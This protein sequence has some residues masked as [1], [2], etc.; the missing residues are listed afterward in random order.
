[1]DINDKIN[2]IK[3][4]TEEIVTED[5]LFNLLSNNENKILKA[6]VGYEPSGKV[7]L[8]H[9][10]T[11]NKLL[12]LQKIGFKIIVLLADIHAYLNKKGTFEKIKKITEYNKKCFIALGLDENKTNF[13][14]GSTY[15]TNEKYI[16][17]VLKMTK[18]IT[19]N[20]SNRSMD[21]VG[22]QMENPM[23]SQLLYPIMQCIDIAELDIDIAIGGIDQR[24]I[25]ML[26]RE[27]L[28][29]LGYKKPICIHI[30]IMLGLDGKKMSSSNDNFIS[31]DDTSDE[32][33]NKIMKG[34][35]EKGNIINNPILEIFKYHVFPRYTQ[36]VINRS[37]KFGGNIMY[38]KYEDLE[39]DFE[40]LSIHPFDLKSAAIKYINEILD[41]VRNVLKYDSIQ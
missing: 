33:K 16:L 41:P 30:P 35:C 4:N 25:H 24:K 29:S 28:E 15:Q 13:V 26:A 21:E 5:E 9:L 11:V 1:M 17:N 34:F 10:M 27:N 3:R 40:N 22:R 14:Y 7:H 8:G 39:Y 18:K 36:L 2:L 38:D 6:Y 32:I 23:V 37:E 20:R 12:D 31:I 19:L